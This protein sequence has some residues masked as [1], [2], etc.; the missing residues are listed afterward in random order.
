M[1]IPYKALFHSFSFGRA[2]K[3]VRD[4]YCDIGVLWEAGSRPYV[5][6]GYIQIQTTIASRAGFSDTKLQ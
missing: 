3:S 6:E 4:G 5:E 1:Y 2:W